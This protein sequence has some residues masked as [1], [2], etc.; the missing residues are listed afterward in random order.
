MRGMADA[1]RD[2]VRWYVTV[3]PNHTEH[4]LAEIARGVAA[5]RSA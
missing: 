2:R 1:D 4:A 5:A 3:N